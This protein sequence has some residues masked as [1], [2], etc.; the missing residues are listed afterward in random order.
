M[1]WP[2][3]V[4]SPVY[5]KFKDWKFNGLLKSFE[6]S[7]DT[8]G[9]KFS[10]SVDSPAAIL[11]GTKVILGDFMGMTAPFPN[12]QGSVCEAGGYFILLMF[13]VIM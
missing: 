8:G 12:L 2:H 11:R 6:R 7:L 13:L 10:V 5:F 1:F 9:E 3:E 4:G